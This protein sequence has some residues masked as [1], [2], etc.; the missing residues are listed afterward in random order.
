MLIK[1]VRALPG[2]N[3]HLD[4]PVLHAR[5][6]LGTLSE[7]ESVE[8]PRFNDRLLGLLGGLADHHCGLGYPGGF[9]ERLREGT[10][11][12][13]IVEHVAIELQNMVGI[14][15]NY[16]KTRIAEA[17]DKYDMIVEYRNE[18]A[19]R[20]LLQAACDLVDALAKGRP[21]APAVLEEM[22][23][24]A[25]RILEDTELGPSTRAIVDAA[26]QRGI[27]WWRLDDDSLV[28]P[29]HGRQ[30]RTIRAAVGERTGAL[31]V[32]M[33]GDKQ[34]TKRLLDGASIPTPR[35]IVARSLEEA[36]DSLNELRLPVA[37]K[38]L[39]GNQG[40]GVSLNLSTA[41]Q[42]SEAWKS[43]CALS[44]SVVVEEFLQGRD[45][46]VLVVGGKVVAA[47]ERQPASV[48][49]DGVRSIAKLVE[50]ENRNPQCGENH[51]KPLTK[52]KLDAQ[53]VAL[54]A[55]N[56]RTLDDIPA[57]GEQVRLCQT[58][59][60]S[61]GGT[62]RDVTDEIHP[63]V[64]CV[65]ERAARVI[66][67]DICGVDLI[68]PDISRPLP[69]SG[70]G[71]VELN[72]SPGIRM[73]HFPGAGSPRDVGSAIVKM[74]FPGSSQGRIPIV[75][76]TGTNGKTTVTR[77][78]ADTL[79]RSGTVVGMTTTEGIWIDGQCV[80]RGDLT[81]F[82]S[83]RSVLGDPAVEAAVLET[84]RGGILRRSLGYDWSDVGV[85]TNIQA[86]HLGQEGIK[87]VDD[88]L[89]VKSLVAE[90]VREGGTLVL[91][92]DD[93]RLAA[94]PQ[95]ERVVRLPRRIVYFS[96]DPD[97]EMIRKH[98]ADNGTAFL[99][100]DGWLVESC[101]RTTYRIVRAEAIPATLGGAA[102]F[103]IAN[104]LAAAAA[105]RALGGS[106]QEVAASLT[107]FGNGVDNPGRLSTYR[108]GNGYL[109]A[110]YGH[111]PA[112]LA[113]L[114]ELALKWTNRRV[115]AVVGLPGDRCDALIEDAAR[116][117]ADC[118]DRIIIREDADLRGR[119][120]GAVPRLICQAVAAIDPEQTCRVVPDEAQALQ[121]AV[122]DMKDGE[123]IVW[124]FEKLAAAETI[125]ERLGARPI[126]AT[127]LA[128][129][130]VPLTPSVDQSSFIAA[131]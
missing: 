79:S 110:D 80:A 100:A 112:A 87:T 118:Y 24:K 68:A 63:E 45:Y 23:G 44:S 49:G 47:S 114:R 15:V 37:V 66:G 76:I 16:G 93:E 86:D 34:L 30:R 88:L 70:A 25:S 31:A 52:I 117:L 78:I 71:I 22:L 36:L 58:A 38:P 119:G 97:N 103:Q 121:E 115:T 81:G 12:G 60:L 65:C 41:D 96:L 39:N 67:L 83:A 6:E 106:R 105:C 3:V 50:A 14:A 11:F 98:L 64:A 69:E 104:A 95:N 127:E 111:N 46:R 48:V 59:N 55:Q 125:L 7:V 54:L 94:L 130:T 13:H 4:R 10:Y 35:G 28:L 99:F 26:E 122:N 91:N 116:N 108:V 56:G 61:T 51:E 92:A 42:V 29:G 21:Y 102:E 75:A 18:A 17:P 20:Y 2:P 128:R 124:F 89:H 19:A 107:Q 101:G 77:M 72:A 131:S 9:V 126:E 33:A 57:V 1:S 43:A 85:I 120:P 40:R 73:H 82:Q 129:L 32:E 8:I 74:L 27:P 62:A 53:A 113:A 123:V 109:V 84:A 90:R 5:I